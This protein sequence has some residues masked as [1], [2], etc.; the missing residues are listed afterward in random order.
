LLFEISLES[1]A[2]EPSADRVESG[3]ES[4]AWQAE[5]P[6]RLGDGVRVANPVRDD[7]WALRHRFQSLLNVD[8]QVPKRLLVGLLWIGTSLRRLGWPWPRPLLGQ[9]V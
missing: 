5:V 3:I 7:A 8:D 2:L 6:S 4:R 9:E 1:T